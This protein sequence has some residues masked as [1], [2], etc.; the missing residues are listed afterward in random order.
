MR[1]HMPFEF[2]FTN[3]RST[4]DSPSPGGGG[5]YRIARCDTGWGDG[6]SS[7]TPPVLRDHPTPVFI[8]L[9]CMQTDP[10]PLGEGDGMRLDRLPGLDRQRRILGPF[11]HRAVVEREVVV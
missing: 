4:L 6:L 3:A 2:E 10:P 1:T 7:R 8:P 5:S 9:R 11:A